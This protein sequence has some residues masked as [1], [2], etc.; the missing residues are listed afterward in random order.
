MKLLISFCLLVILAQS[1][2]AEKTLREKARNYQPQSS[3]T[4]EFN[5]HSLANLHPW[6][7]GKLFLLLD[8][9]TSDT[10]TLTT[11]KTITETTIVT[12]RVYQPYSELISS[13][14]FTTDFSTVGYGPSVSGRNFEDISFDAYVNDRVSSYNPNVVTNGISSNGTPPVQG[15]PGYPAP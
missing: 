10:K 14:T 8:P 9:L 4:S 13:Q 7:N 1:A 2:F 11:T 15:I 3:V 12:T 6:Y 5:S